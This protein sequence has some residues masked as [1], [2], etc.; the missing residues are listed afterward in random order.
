MMGGNDPLVKG[1]KPHR[2]KCSGEEEGRKTRTARR[3]PDQNGNTVTRKKI[4]VGFI[5][6]PDS[7]F[8]MRTDS[9]LGPAF[10]SY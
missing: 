3:L 9:N 4:H 8:L 1:E 5:S 10:C 7:I 2:G 6:K